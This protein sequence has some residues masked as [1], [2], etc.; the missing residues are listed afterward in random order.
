MRHPALL[1]SE[2]IESIKAGRVIL[3]HPLPASLSELMARN[4]RIAAILGLPATVV[5]IAGM[6]SYFQNRSQRN[7]WQAAR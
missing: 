7:K 3:D 2:D 1:S 5:F 6:F 4:I